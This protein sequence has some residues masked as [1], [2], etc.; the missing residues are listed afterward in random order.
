[1][2]PFVSPDDDHARL[3]VPTANGSEPVTGDDFGGLTALAARP[4]NVSTA[5]V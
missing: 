3:A 5:L 4:F 1:M 2:S